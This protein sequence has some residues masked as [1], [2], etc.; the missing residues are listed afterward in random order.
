MAKGTCAAP[1][2]EE[3]TIGRGW[4]RKHYLRWWRH[5]SIEDP[6]PT[7]E[8][9]F[10][11]QVDRRGPD[12]CWLWKKPRADGYGYFWGQGRHGD[13]AD[14]AHRFAYKLLVGPI[15]DE[16]ELDHVKERG[17]ASRACV[18]PAH[19][20]PVTPRENQER[21]DTFTAR[22]VAKTRCPQGH[23]YDAAN[24]YITAKGHR[25]CRA[26]R[27]SRS[28]RWQATRTW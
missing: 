12:E 14:Y 27:R 25:Q 15:P 6:R 8:Q 16:L 21:G 1:D 5:G 20:E 11:R 3:P 22:A 19:L 4:C 7:L 10:W 13:H 26:C 28:Q 23:P 2:C 17:C 9:R 24:T 18:N